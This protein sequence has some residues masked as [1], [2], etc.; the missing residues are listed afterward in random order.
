MDVQFDL[1]ERS[2]WTVLGVCGEIDVFSS[3]QLHEQLVA[4]DEAG[5]NQVVV[6]LDGVEFLDSTGLAVLIAG[7]KRARDRRGDLALVCSRRPL[8]KLFS[9]T[10]LDEAFALHV[11]V[12]DAVASAS[13]RAG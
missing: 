1:S 9:L 2:D 13:S 12:D 11:T 5:H 3:Q 7:R 8:L 4:I 10:G 6:N